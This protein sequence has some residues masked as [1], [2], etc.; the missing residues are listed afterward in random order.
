MTDTPIPIS[1]L[2][3]GTTLG[4][5][6]IKSLLGRGGMAEVYRAIN[7]D[8]NQDV[9]IKV[10]HPNV[11]NQ[12][13]AA[14]RFQREAQAAAS[15]S[16]PNIIKIFDFSVEGGLYYMVMEVLEGVT[17][18]HVIEQHVEGMPYD[19]LMGI[20][21]Q[22]ASAVGYAHEK[23]VI[24]RDI[25]PS[26]ILMV[27]DRAVLMDF[28]LAKLAGQASLTATGMSSGT[29]AYMAPEQA[30]GQEITP[31]T[32]IYALGVLLYE[33]ATGQVPFKGDTFANVLIKHLQAP[34][35]RASEMVEN[36]APQIEPVILRAMS[37]QSYDR[38]ER[39]AD[40]VADLESTPEGLHQKT[41][42]ISQQAAAGLIKTDDETITIEALNAIRASSITPTVQTRFQ[43]RWLGLIFVGIVLLIVVGLGILLTLN[44]ADSD[45]TDSPSDDNQDPISANITIPEGM[46]YIPGGTFIQGTND[47]P[48][49]EGPAHEVTLNPFLIDQFEVTNADYLDFVLERGYIEPITW[50][51]DEPSVWE[52]RG[53][54][55]YRFGDF[56]NRGAYDGQNVIALNDA[57]FFLALDA[58]NETGTLELAFQGTIDPEGTPLTGEFRIVQTAFTETERFH[59]GG[60]GDHVLMHGDSGQ[61]TGL[62]PRIIAPLATWGKGD[63]YKDGELIYSNVGIHFMLTPGVHDEQNRILKADQTCCFS[64]R[65]PAD[66]YVNLDEVELS[67][68]IFEGGDSNTGYGPAITPG[69]VSETRNIWVSLFFNTVNIGQ[70]PSTSIAQFPTSTE[71]QPVTGVSWEDA[72]A[73]CAWRG[74]RLPTEAEWEFA[75]RGTDER[76]YPWGNERIVNEVMPAN[77]ENTTFDLTDVGTFPDGASPFLVFDMAG[78]AWEW[79]NDR[80]EP[81]YYQQGETDNPRGPRTGNIRVVRGGGAVPREPFGVSEFRTTAR[82]GLPQ[83]IKDPTIGFRCGADILVNN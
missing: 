54:D 11:S 3:A 66:G 46:V 29:P 67:I 65:N 13:E 30:S 26:N 21:R 41:I 1:Y 43:N 9:A 6:T 4:K 77:V 17:L 58:D 25:K 8:L 19:Q 37:K 76:T 23:G 75:A 45:N 48:A 12:Q 42:Y 10:L 33:M 36:L 16:H 50:E 83:D 64:S 22:I 78:N 61:E 14:Q 69:Q 35:P 52:I 28:G 47:G 80:Y 71:N 40:M 24:H 79:V 27:G 56:V 34:P 68:M 51:R 82:L 39:V 5:Y 63:I 72:A 73:Y 7:P 70:A 74:K 15:L 60:I 62:I 49:E 59:E 38:Y 44:N 31:Q 2:A 53:T 20:F 81:E 32:D 18:S 57:T 55:A